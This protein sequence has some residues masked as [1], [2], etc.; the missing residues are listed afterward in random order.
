MNFILPYY[1][2]KSATTT[3]SSFTGLTKSVTAKGQKQ[4]KFTTNNE[5]MVIAYDS[6]YGNL[7]SILDPNGFETISGWTKSTLTVG[8]FSYFVYVANSATTDTN[9]QFTFKY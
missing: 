5:Y 1:Y 3:V 4:F 6:S 2:G 8:G 7:S 9:A